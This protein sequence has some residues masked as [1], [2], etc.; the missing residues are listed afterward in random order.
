MFKL[1]LSYRTDLANVS[2]GVYCHLQALY[3][4]CISITSVS[5]I[6]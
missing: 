2:S 3:S 1:N 5:D 6:R 4:L